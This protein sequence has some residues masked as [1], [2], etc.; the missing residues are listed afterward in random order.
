ML[1]EPWNTRVQ[2]LS[3]K[4]EETQST[5]YDG[6]SE[7]RSLPLRVEAST[8]SKLGLMSKK[9]VQT[10]SLGLWRV[11]T[12]SVRVRPASEEQ[13]PGRDSYWFG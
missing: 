1:G 4:K 10:I 6:T 8:L 12:S 9:R 5:M 2:V 3:D 13:G 7:A 11:L